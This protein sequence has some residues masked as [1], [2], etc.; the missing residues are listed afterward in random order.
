MQ[1]SNWKKYAARDRLLVL[2]AKS[3]KPI[4]NRYDDRL[5]QGSDHDSRKEVPVFIVG[6]PRCGSTLLYQAI[7]N[8]LDV[9][10]INNLTSAFYMNLISGFKISSLIYHDRAHNNFYSRYGTT[11]A[12]GLNAPSECGR[13]WYQWFPREPHFL[14]DDD[15]PDEEKTEI[16]QV[17]STVL[18]TFRRP[19]VLKNLMMGQRIRLLQSMF[20]NAKYIH[21]RRSIVE[22]VDA[23][24]RARRELKI[25]DSDWW[26]VKPKNYREI[27]TLGEVDRSVMQIY[28]TERQIVA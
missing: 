14:S 16:Q 13:F 10:Y 26:S 25:P 19:L 8:Q 21:C 5:S 23:L 12:A 27:Q 3:L 22:N 1:I 2:L 17:I 18:T 20:P 15:V 24:L 9:S 7:T 4:L 6:S 28:E 11:L